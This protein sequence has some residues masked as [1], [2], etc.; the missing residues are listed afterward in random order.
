[1][2]RLV[3]VALI[4]LAAA[5]GY[6]YYASPTTGTGSL[7][8]PQPAPNEGETAPTFE[9]SRKDGALFELSDEGVYVLTFWSMLNKDTAEAR[10]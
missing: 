3:A 1:M 9:A 7:T 8:L 4:V 2:K 5:G 10:P 6:R